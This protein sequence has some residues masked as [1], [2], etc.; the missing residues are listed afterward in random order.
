MRPPPRGAPSPGA[1]PSSLPPAPHSQGGRWVGYDARVGDTRSEIRRRIDAAGERLRAG[2]VDG[3]LGA[4]M[5]GVPPDDIE[6]RAADSARLLSA[7][8]RDMQKRVLGPAPIDPA[9]SRGL[10]QTMSIYVRT[11]GE[12]RHP[13][14]DASLLANLLTDLQFGNLSRRL[15]PPARDR[16]LAA[17][18]HALV[19]LAPAS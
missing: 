16:L 13:A 5:P 19:D 14:E 7:R 8:V 15:P 2:D 11:L 1:A 4:M 18:I 10:A 9:S 6:A 3:A 12:M 17:L